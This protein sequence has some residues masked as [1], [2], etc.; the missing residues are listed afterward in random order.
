MKQIVN[1]SRSE[2]AALDDVVVAVELL[3]AAV[4]EVR[5]ERQTGVDRCPQLGETG[6]RVARGD[7]NLFV[8]Q[9]A[10]DSQAGIAF[11]RQ[12]HEPRQ[13]GRGVQQFLHGAQL[14]KPHGACRM[15]ADEPRLLVEERAFDVNAPDPLG[16]SRIGRASVASL[17]KRA[18]IRSIGAE[19]I[20]AKIPATPSSASRRQARCSASAETSSLL[21]ST[22]A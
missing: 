3:R 2:R 10:G 5:E 14:G 9:K 13:P 19:M 22:P 7:E 12:G 15:G 8:G 1:R 18:A 16:D 6:V 17:A 11:G 20:V 21:K 4:A